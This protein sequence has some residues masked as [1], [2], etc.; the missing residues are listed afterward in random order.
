MTRALYDHGREAFG[1]GQINW[2]ADAILAILVDTALYTVDLA[3]D[4]FLSDIPAPA[5]A[6]TALLA[7]KT[8]VAGVMDATDPTFTDLIGAP[9]MEALVLCKFT[10]DATT[11]RLIMF[12]DEADGLPVSAGA[13]EVT[14]AFSNGAS[15]LFKL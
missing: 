14:V 12:D 15:K 11:S 3:G 5:R 6:A 10:G 1:N 7:G 8:N 9:S 4:V 2:P 13:T